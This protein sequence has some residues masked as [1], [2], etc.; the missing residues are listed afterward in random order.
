MVGNTE[1]AQ[2]GN[3]AKQ[4]ILVCLCVKTV[5]QHTTVNLILMNI[6]QVLTQH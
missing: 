5:T 4:H 1:S 3:L 6:L 2:R